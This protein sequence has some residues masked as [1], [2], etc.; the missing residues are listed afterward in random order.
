MSAN[1][2]WKDIQPF[3]YVNKGLY[4]QQLEEYLKYFPAENI[5]IARNDSLSNN[6]ILKLIKF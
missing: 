3:A 1:K 4:A 5:Y 2:F 6:T